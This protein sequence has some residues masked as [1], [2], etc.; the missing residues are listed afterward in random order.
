MDELVTSSP[1][2]RAGHPDDAEACLAVWV[3]ACA[4]RDGRA[5]DGVADRARPK[6]DGAVAWLVAT[7]DREIDGFV[8]ATGPG[9]GLPS[10]PP[11]SAVLGLLAVSPG[12]Q[13][14]G[15][16]RGL[17]RAAT[18]R[19]SELGY[20]QA[21]LHALI[22]NVLAVRLYES[23]GWTAIGAEYEHSLLK[24]PMRTYARSLSA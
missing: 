11:E 14:H 17:L 10:D 9:S 21:V 8:L 2:L 15:L 12:R 7:D 13:T 3:E 22:D 23:E 24:R 6:F 20:E 19:L 16:G 4:S 18:D 5:H 1:R